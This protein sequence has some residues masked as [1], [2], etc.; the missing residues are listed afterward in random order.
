LMLISC[1]PSSDQH[2]VRPYQ[3]DEMKDSTHSVTRL[4]APSL[5]IDTT[6]EKWTVSFT[7]LP[8][9]KNV[10]E[11]NTEFEITE[12]LF[13]AIEVLPPVES[14]VRLSK[15]HLLVNGKPGTTN[16]QVSEYTFQML[17]AWQRQKMKPTPPNEGE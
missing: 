6:A 15:R 2:Q 8:G 13:M 14:V 3:L 5:V 11:I 7:T 4:V 12:G 9:L 17:C 16:K 1:N 10:I